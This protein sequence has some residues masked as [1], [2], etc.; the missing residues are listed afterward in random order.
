MSSVV[1]G[2]FAAR[3][4]QGGLLA[5]VPVPGAARFC[6][7][8]TPDNPPDDAAGPGRLRPQGNGGEQ[9]R[10][11]IGDWLCM[12]G[13]EHTAIFYM[14]PPEARE[15]LSV[16]GIDP[17][18]VCR[19]DNPIHTWRRD[20]SMMLD[21]EG[22]ERETIYFGPVH[23]V[24][25]HADHVS[26]LV[27]TPEG[28]HVTWLPGPPLHPHALRLLWVTIWIWGPGCWL[29]TLLRLVPS[30]EVEEWYARGFR[31]RMIPRPRD[32]WVQACVLNVQKRRA[33]LASQAG[34]GQDPCQPWL[35]RAELRRLYRMLGAEDL[36]L[37]LPAPFVVPKD[38]DGNDLELRLRGC[39]CINCDCGWDRNYNR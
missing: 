7:A 6:A 24:Q 2:L 11:E 9:P 26:V 8:M 39:D 16:E 13:P 31:N 17:G 29:G 30:E 1:V 33:A 12:A 35:T 10:P 15:A 28:R 37:S 20:P 22:P 5:A 14:A 36:L 18:V 27:P 4:L 25:S 3:G 32:R 21:P 23:A 34:S 19:V 38:S